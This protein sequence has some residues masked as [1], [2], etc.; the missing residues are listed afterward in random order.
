VPGNR[1]GLGPSTGLDRR[2]KPCGSKNWGKIGASTERRHVW[3]LSEGNL[4]RTTDAAQEKEEGK[5]RLKQSLWGSEKAGALAPISELK[6][7][8]GEEKKAGQLTRAGIET[9]I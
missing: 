1:A 8:T 4:F 5:R 3:A 6:K 7:K 9:D 2:G